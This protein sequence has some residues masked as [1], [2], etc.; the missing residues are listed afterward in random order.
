MRGWTWHAARATARTCSPGPPRASSRRCQLPQAHEH[1]RLRYRRRTSAFE[2]DLVETFTHAADAVG[3][4]AD[5]RARQQSGSGARALALA[6]RGHTQP[7]G[8]GRGVVFV[9]TPNVLT[10]APAG[11]PR[12]DNPW[13]VTVTERESFRRC[14]KRISGPWRCTGLLHA[15]KLRVHEH[16]C[17]WLGTR[18]TCACA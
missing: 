13:H 9:S 2:R 18:C 17:G 3:F 14:A 15:R 11:A 8:L 6:R 16:A 5:D 10:L 4:P 7:G 1:A 12:S